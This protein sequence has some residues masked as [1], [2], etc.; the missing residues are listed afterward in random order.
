[1]ESRVDKVRRDLRRVLRFL[2]VGC[3]LGAAVAYPLL[4]A[5]KLTGNLPD[6]LTWAHVALGPLVGY[7]GL[8]VMSWLACRLDLRK[9]KKEDRR[10]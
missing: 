10:T 4:I 1:M 5:A 6:R 9:A 7:G 3:L 8:V 2:L